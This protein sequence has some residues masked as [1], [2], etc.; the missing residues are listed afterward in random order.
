PPYT[1]IRPRP[2]AKHTISGGKKKKTTSP[3]KPVVGQ[4]DKTV[5]YYRDE[6]ARY[7][8]RRYRVLAGREHTAT[9]GSSLGGLFSTY[10]A[11]E[12]ADFARHHAALSPSYWITRIPPGSLEM[13]ER[14]RTGQPRDIRLWLDSGTL[15]SP[16]KGDDG[17]KDTMAAREAL[18]EN[19]YVIGPDFQH[20][21]AEGAIHH[22]SAWAARLDNVFRFL[23]PV[24]TENA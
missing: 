18:L 3:L 8:E 20:H 22:E 12:H 5:A 7:V 9:C 2:P 19:G 1:T 17:L 6:V 10:I 13:V 4:A 15:D 24:Q 16:S 21:V 14:L 11:W 23:F